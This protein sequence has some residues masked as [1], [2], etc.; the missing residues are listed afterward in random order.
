VSLFGFLGKFGRHRRALGLGEK[1][2]NLHR[3]ELMSQLASGMAHDLYNIIVII[4]GNCDLLLEHDLPPH[5]YR[6]VQRI[7]MA[8]TH[9]SGFLD[10][11]LCFARG[12]SP[13]A[14]TTEIDS[15][16]QNIEPLLLSLLQQGAQ[17]KMDLQADGAHINIAPVFFSQ[18]VLNLVLNARDALQHAGEICVSTSRL[19][20]E[21]DQLASSNLP[22]GEYV[23]LEV[24][25]N[26]HGMDVQTGLHIFEPFFS[27]KEKGKGS[28]LGL[29]IVNAVVS[30]SG[31]EVQ[32]T[33]APDR[34]TTVRVF[35]PKAYAVVCRETD[36]Q[37]SAR[38]R[39]NRGSDMQ[40]TEL[41][42]V[43]LP[44]QLCCCGEEA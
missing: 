17:L 23:L 8:A 36:S 15:A 33:S 39:S 14:A 7:R 4:K 37:P 5:V 29:T 43:W 44:D 13:Q 25:D 21:P 16:I 19:S 27:T 11:L 3:M 1:L 40:S 30:Q 34:G 31:G 42:A 20:L 12:E 38:I 22:A 26:G 28:G 41:P 32:V 10:T 35:L 9:G 24:A 18:I 6:S 2:R